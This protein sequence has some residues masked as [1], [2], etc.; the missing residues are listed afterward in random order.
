MTTFITGGTS[1]IGRVLVKEMARQGEALRVLVRLNSDRAGLEL[2][3]VTFVAGDVTD[4][5][6]VREGMQGCSQ[7]TH[8]AAVVGQNVPEAT[9]W[10]VNRDGTRNVLQAALDQ[11]IQSMVQ[12]STVG[13]FGPTRAGETA[14]ETRSID[15]A[16]YTNLY[17]KTKHAADELARDF[18]ARGLPV[19]IVYP[20]FG[21][22]CSRASHPSL[23]DQTLLA[24]AAGKSVAIMGSGRNRLTIAYYRDTVRGILLAHQRAKPGD[25]FILGGEA[26][27]F[28]QIWSAIAGVLGKPPPTRHVPLGLLRFVAQVSRAVTGRSLLPPEILEMFAFDWVF[29]SA[30]ATR[31]LGWAHTPFAK[32]VAETWQE[33]QA[34]G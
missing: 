20:C 19:A 24:M 33:Y 29:S 2:P 22:G 27:T 13:V 18:A 16:R 11:G 30:K 14:D 34:L 28:P 6:S 32:A 4:L 3:G 15:P 21:F 12:V 8:L 17:Q 31:L 1:S 23:Q 9:W 7:V 25:D 5:R 26:L 10:A